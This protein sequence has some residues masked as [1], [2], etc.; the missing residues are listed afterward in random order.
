MAIALSRRTL[1]RAVTPAAAVAAP[2]ALAGV[3]APGALAKAPAADC[4]P[5]SGR[6]CLLPFPDN[7]LTRADRTSRTRL[8]VQLPPAAMPSNTKGVRVRVAPYD[9]NDG[10]SPG[11]TIIVHVPGLTTARAFAR[12]GIVPLTNQ[13]ASLSGASRSSSS[14]RRPTAASWSGVS[15]TPMPGGRPTPTCSSTRP[16]I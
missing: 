8:R 5:Y 7:R 14:T 9:R 4:Q 11:S 3:A 15:S 10:F 12:T 2:A 1:R 16:G 13:A 6:P